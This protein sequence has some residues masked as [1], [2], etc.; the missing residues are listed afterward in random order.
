[1]HS[2][3]FSLD[4]CNVLQHYVGFSYILSRSSDIYNKPPPHT[5]HL[6]Y[7]TVCAKKKSAFFTSYII[8]RQFSLKLYLLYSYIYYIYVLHQVISCWNLDINRIFFF[9]QSKHQNKTICRAWHVN[10]G[11]FYLMILLQGSLT[12]V[13]RLKPRNRPGLKSPI[14]SM[15]LEKTIERFVSFVS[16]VLVLWIC[17]CLAWKLYLAI[18]PCKYFVFV[19]QPYYVNLNSKLSYFWS[20]L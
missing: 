16:G 2:H 14:R 4:C 15:A 9:S 11:G 13:C 1:M 5:D 12:V 17:D 3:L 20:E 10:D 19:V 7:Y 8:L 6:L 18:F